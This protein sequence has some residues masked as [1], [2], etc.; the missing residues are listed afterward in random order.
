[1]ASADDSD[2]NRSTVCYIRSLPITSLDCRFP[3][4]T[5]SIFSYLLRLTIS[6]VSSEGLKITSYEFEFGRLMTLKGAMKR[7]M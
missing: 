1:M 2:C 6:C 5:S 3:P 7:S 4:P